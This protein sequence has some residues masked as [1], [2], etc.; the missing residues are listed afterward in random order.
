MGIKSR[1]CTFNTVKRTNH[2]TPSNSLLTHPHKSLTPLFKCDYFLNVILEMH[3]LCAVTCSKAV[4][5]HAHESLLSALPEA[6][7]RLWW[8]CICSQGVV[9]ILSFLLCIFSHLHCPQNLNEPAE[10]LQTQVFSFW[11]TNQWTSLTVRFTD[12][13][14]PDCG[15]DATPV[16]QT[17]QSTFTCGSCSSF[18]TC[19]TP[20]INTVIQNA[21]VKPLCKENQSKFCVYT[22]VR[23]LENKRVWAWINQKNK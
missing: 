17:R 20:R 5:K 9:T 11:L 19:F 8:L 1:L 13:I 2:K 3:G 16:P 7:H 12:A 14:N 23:L 21:K 15:G 18:S 22:F 6:H 10:W 4:Q